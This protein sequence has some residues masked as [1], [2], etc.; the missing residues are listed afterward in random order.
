MSESIFEKELSLP[1]ADLSRYSSR[2]IGFEHRYADLEK[3]L[4]LLM[5]QEGLEAWSKKH[6]GEVLPFISSLADRYPL[7][8]FF[9][10]VGTGKTAMAEAISNRIAKDIGADGNLFK[11]S[12][13][14]RGTGSVGQMSSLINQAFEIAH[15][16]AKKEKLSFL[17]ID[18][19]DSLAASRNQAQS[20]HEDKVAVNTLIQKVDEARKLKGR[21]LIFLC[22]NRYDAI[23]PAILRRA[24]LHVEFARPSENERRELFEFDLAGMGFSSDELDQIVSKTGSTPTRSLTYT[25]S[26][27]RT[28]V[29]PQALAYAFPESGMKLEHILQAIDQVTPS[30]SILN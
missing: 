5:D 24:A 28:R 17:I 16:A 23:D 18:E 19:A 29:M 10:D 11:L 27:L 13:R 3:W 9:G 4:R 7:I 15:N 22:T 25:F 8:V 1:D 21:L 2:L 30:P 20:H 14:V 26:D 6:Y 12:T